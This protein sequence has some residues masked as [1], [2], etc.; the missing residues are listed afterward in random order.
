MKRAKESNREQRRT[1]EPNRAMKKQKTTNPVFKI[2]QGWH[3]TH[4]IK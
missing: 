2:G 3:K 1:R 4:Q